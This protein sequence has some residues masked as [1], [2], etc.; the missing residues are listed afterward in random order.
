MIEAKQEVGESQAEFTPILL[1]DLANKFV[2]S[3]V[4]LGE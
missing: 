2:Q 3:L 1:A 4:D